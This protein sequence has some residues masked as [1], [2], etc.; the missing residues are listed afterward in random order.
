ME[1]ER[2]WTRGKDSACSGSESSFEVTTSESPD[3]M[4]K[5]GG[6]VTG[7][8]G[9]MSVNQGVSHEACDCRKRISDPVNLPGP[10]SK[11]RSSSSSATLP[12]QLN[13]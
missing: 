6:S 13:R 9:G 10:S 3:L 7:E 8:S 1:R 11:S 12:R 4:V 5:T 2:T